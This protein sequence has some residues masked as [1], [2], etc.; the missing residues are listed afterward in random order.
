MIRA[1]G[2]YI[3]STEVTAAQYAIFDKLKGNDT[4]GQP[5]E[6]SWNS[7][8]DP[9]FEPGAVLVLPNHPVTNIDFCDAKAYC[10]WADKR[11]CGKISGGP[12]QLPETAD[13]AQSQWFAAC[14]G[15]MSQ[16]YPYG[17]M[18]ETATCNDDSK[19]LLDVSAKS[20][21]QG[22]YPGL[23]DMLGNAQEWVDSCQATTG[24]TDTCE[25]I[26][27]SFATGQSVVCST[28]GAAE[29]AAYSQSVGF[30]CCSTV[31]PLTK[32]GTH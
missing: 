15:P 22:Y 3:D 6:C 26:G 25:R 23:Y 19:A 16:Q 7:S 28:S 13:S 30:R 12:L 31:K 21:C 17:T 24:K 27:G 14:A 2:Y 5:A 10:A 32:T 29:R 20:K 11:L 1:D 18:H 4:S 9:V 8:F